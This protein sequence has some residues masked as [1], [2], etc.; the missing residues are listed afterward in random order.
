M[1]SVLHV[2]ADD[3]ST[4][5]TGEDLARI[6]P[7]VL[8]AGT[9]VSIEKGGPYAP[10]AIA[11]A[12]DGLLRDR[13]ASVLATPSLRG[14]VATR[15]AILA[16]TLVPLGLLLELDRE[17]ATKAQAAP[18]RVVVDVLLAAWTLWELT[19]R[20]PRLPGIAAI[21]MLAVGSRWALVATRHCGTDG[22][23]NAVV[24]LNVALAFGAA[25][26]LATI[27]PSRGRVA[28]ELLGKLGIE[29]ADILAARTR[30]EA[31]AALV[32]AAIGCAAGLPALLFLFRTIRAGMLVEAAGFALYGVG[33]PLLIRRFFDTVPEAR[34]VRS[35]RAILEATAAGLTLAAAAVTVGHL[36]FDNTA[37]LARCFHRLG[38]EAKLARAAESA[39]LTQAIGRVRAD[40]VLFVLTAAVFPFAEERIFRGLLQ[41]VF[42]RKY[43]RAYS[44]F[45]ASV[46]F[47]V[48]HLGVYE[49]A[50]YQTV[51]LG[52]GFG[53][54]YGEGGLLAAFFVHATWNLIQL[55]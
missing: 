26:A 17:L 33:A 54:A 37:E 45:A 51:L 13:L 21:A 35:P 4:T 44:I 2:C 48:A 38:D 6:E 29:R 36:F 40:A 19:R 42:E 16:I 50:L 49:V 18:S 30:P 22:R 55:A 31:D 43:G 1:R 41:D 53:V 10:L 11:V 28:Q 52:I 46:A 23:M 24:Y 12:T 5:F 7:G 3:V 39:E 25:A 20:T 9:L 27:V 47:G 34:A 8:R 15:W 32:A 14:G